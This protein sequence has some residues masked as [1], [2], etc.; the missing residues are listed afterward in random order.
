[1]P[2]I[3]P[4]ERTARSWWKNLTGLYSNLIVGAEV[5]E[6]RHCPMIG[7]VLCGRIVPV[8]HIQNAKWI[9][10]RKRSQKNGCPLGQ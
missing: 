1:M 10:A 3:D 9:E 7:G 4:P 5:V 8:V 6:H 2:S